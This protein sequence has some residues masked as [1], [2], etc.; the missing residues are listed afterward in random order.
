MQMTVP[1][2]NEQKKPINSAKNSRYI[3][4]TLLNSNIHLPVIRA[5]IQNNTRAN[6]PNADKSHITLEIKVTLKFS[7]LGGMEFPFIAA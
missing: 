7:R 1:L 6:N 2:I 4:R 5:G 3:V